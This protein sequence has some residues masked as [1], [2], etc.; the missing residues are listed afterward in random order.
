MKYYYTDATIAELMEDWHGIWSS[1]DIKIYSSPPDEN[2]EG[3]SLLS[4]DSEIKWYIDPSCYEM[5]KPQ[6]DDLITINNALSANTITHQEFLEEL[7]RLHPQLEAPPQIIQ[8][9]GKA[10]FMPESEEIE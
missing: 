2:T 10:F 5:L 3:R 9:N 6:V 1:H 7:G 4:V 8:R